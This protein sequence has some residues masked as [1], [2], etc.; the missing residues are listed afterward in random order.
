MT[1]HEVLSFIGQFRDYLHRTLS[2]P[3]N[4]PWPTREMVADNL[5]LNKGRYRNTFT[6]SN[7]RRQVAILKRKGLVAE[8][9]CQPHCHATH[10][11]LTRLGEDMLAVMN[12]AGCHTCLHRKEPCVAELTFRR[13]AA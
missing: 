2:R 11:S 3:E 9:P 1:E 10:V 12:Q 6:H 7:F 5:T 4:L 8:G 13:F